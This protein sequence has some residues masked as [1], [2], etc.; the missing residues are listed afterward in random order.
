MEAISLDPRA[1]IELFP[2]GIVDRVC[3]LHC[4]MSLSPRYLLL[5]VSSGLIDLEHGT[6]ANQILTSHLERQQDWL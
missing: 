1:E 4:Q 5:S 2:S 6:Q 3:P